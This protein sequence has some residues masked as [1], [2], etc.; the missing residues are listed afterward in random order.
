MTDAESGPADAQASAAGIFAAELKAQRG[1]LGWTQVQLGE[2]IGYSGSFISDV[3]RGAR[4]A[5]L[6]FAQRC[7][8]E[9]GLPGTLERMHELTRREAYPSWFSPVIPFEAASVRI[10]GWALGAVPGLLQ[11]ESYAR[12]VIQ[13]R[14]PQSEEDAIER[15]VAAR[16]ERQAI[17]A[18]D[19]R[20]LLWYVLH[21][22]LLRHLIGDREIMAGQLDKLIKSATMPGV[23]LQVLPF[24]AHDHA[25]VEGPIVLY[26]SHR[27][28]T[29]A[30]TECYGGGR[31]V[32]AIDEVADLMT[33]V[34]MLRAAALPPRDSLAFMKQIRSDLDDR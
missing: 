12:S 21:E 22:G 16:I 27:G 3:E 7:D 8:K 20:P 6:D 24:T 15:T 17:L 28:P 29:V 13:A 25:G 18:R 23:M 33:V 11:T 14:R 4:W 31:L 19:N 30:Y 34:G 26:E 2:R 5:S 1:R 10:H 9:L 32:E